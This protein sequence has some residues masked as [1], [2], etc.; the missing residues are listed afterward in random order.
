MTIKPTP[1]KDVLVV[2]AIGVYLR[3]DI[4]K[5]RETIQNQIDKGNV[6]VIDSSMEAVGIFRG[7]ADK[8]I[9]EVI[10]DFEPIPKVGWR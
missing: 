7:L 8:M 3:N 1:E 4:E 6:V 9:V 10:G 2:R 5:M